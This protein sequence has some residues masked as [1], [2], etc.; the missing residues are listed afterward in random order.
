M[1]FVF[2]LLFLFKVVSFNII[3]T[4]FRKIYFHQ[5]VK[6]FFQKTAKFSIYPKGFSPWFPSQ[7]WR[8]YIF[9]K[10]FANVLDTKEAFQDY[11][12][13][14]TQNLVTSCNPL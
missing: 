4:R 11:W 8:F 6:T 12:L 9:S 5:S 2:L 7:R 1:V 3:I 14:K 13:R 10:L